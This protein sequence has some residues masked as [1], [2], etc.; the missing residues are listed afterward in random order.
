[1]EGLAT[2]MGAIWMQCVRQKLEEGGGWRVFPEKLLGRK[3]KKKD[4]QLWDN[5]K[6]K[7]TFSLGNF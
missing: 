4:A 1:M 3:K 7:N 2:R 6:Y 5:L